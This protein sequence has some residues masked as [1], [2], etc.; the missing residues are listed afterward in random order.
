MK[1]YYMLG[2]GLYFQC[3]QPQMIAEKIIAN[4]DYR[5][6]YDECLEQEYCQI[7]VCQ[8]AGRVTQAEVFKMFMHDEYE[9]A[10]S[11]FMNENEEDWIGQMSQAIEAMD[12]GQVLNFTRFTVVCVDSDQ[13]KR[14]C[15]A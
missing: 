12:A 5:P 8:S 4:T 10:Y 2:N 7:A 14:F 3:A 11:E 1:V 9:E 13:T 15:L 6:H